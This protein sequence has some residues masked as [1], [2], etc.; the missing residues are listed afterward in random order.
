MNVPQSVCIKVHS[1]TNGCWCEVRVQCCSTEHIMSL[2][3]QQQACGY[4]LAKAPWQ[5]PIQKPWTTICIVIYALLSWGL[6]QCVCIICYL[7]STKVWRHQ[8]IFFQHF[9]DLLKVIEPGQFTLISMGLIRYSCGH[10]Y[11]GPWT[12]FH[13]IWCVEV[14]HH[15]LLKYEEKKIMKMLKNSFDDVITGRLFLPGI[16]VCSEAQFKGDFFFFREILS[17]ISREIGYKF[18]KISLKR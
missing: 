3:L 17:L 16:H 4:C 8:N 18:G 1:P 11:I 13:Q 2:G 9:H 6:L 15:G 12:D 5:L 7:Y 10:I 14:F